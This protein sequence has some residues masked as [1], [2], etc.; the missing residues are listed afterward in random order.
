MRTACARSYAT[1][2]SVYRYDIA[3]AEKQ[4]VF[5]AKVAMN[6]ADYEVK[7]VFYT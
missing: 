5:R 3:T 2:P 6:P 4:L 1:P 7:Q